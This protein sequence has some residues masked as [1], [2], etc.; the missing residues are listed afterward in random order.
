MESNSL[1]DYSF[2]YRLHKDEHTAKAS[3]NVPIE[4]PDQ[5]FMEWN[6]LL[7]RYIWAGKKPRI[8][9]NNWRKIKEG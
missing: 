3:Q 8:R 2:T 1:H 9:Y 6:K 7:S 5:Y 4:K